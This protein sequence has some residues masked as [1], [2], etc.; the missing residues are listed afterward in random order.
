MN[1]HIYQ[2]G[3]AIQWNRRSI[4]KG[5]KLYCRSMS[6]RINCWHLKARRP[7]RKQTRCI[8]KGWTCRIRFFKHICFHSA[9][10]GCRTAASG[11]VLKTDIATGNGDVRREFGLRAPSCPQYKLVSCWLKA[12]LEKPKSESKHRRKYPKHLLWP[13][14]AFL[15]SDTEFFCY[16]S[17]HV[18]GLNLKDEQ[19]ELYQTSSSRSVRSKPRNLSKMVSGQ[20]RK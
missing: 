20:K 3:W 6:L 19:A 17:A 12:N 13:K 16:F 10:I 8:H 1:I 4:R 9:Y 11:S 7:V 18:N 15:I 5:K 2:A 14:S